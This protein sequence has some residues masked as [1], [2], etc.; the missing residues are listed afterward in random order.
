MISIKALHLTGAAILV[1][2]GNLVL[3]AAPSG[4]QHAIAGFRRGNRMPSKELI[5][6]KTGAEIRQALQRR[7]AD[8]EARLA[9]RNVALEELL[10]DKARVRAYLVGQIN[11]TYT[12]Q[13]RLGEDVPSEEHQEIAELCRR[14]SNIEA[15]LARLRLIQA[16]LKDTQ[17]FELTLEQLVSYGFS[18]QPPANI[19]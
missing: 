4:A 2:R 19:A 9:K 11:R 14:V 17:E 10:S 1:S 12:S 7:I 13:H 16:H 6:L 5:F 18:D 3:Q 15:E 8:L